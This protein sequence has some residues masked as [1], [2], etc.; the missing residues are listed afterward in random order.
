VPFLRHASW[1]TL[2]NEAPAWDNAR[3]AAAVHSHLNCALVEPG[4]SDPQEDRRYATP[5]PDA[6]DEG[7]V[8]RTAA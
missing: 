4:D 6:P 2:R 8:S 7:P 1:L 3:H 5:R